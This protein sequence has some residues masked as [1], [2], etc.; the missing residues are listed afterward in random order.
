MGLRLKF[1]LVLLGVFIV[2]LAVSGYTSYELLRRNAMDE[3]ARSAGLMMEAASAIRAYT[4]NHLR[5]KLAATPTDRFLPQSVPAFAATETLNALRKKYPEFAYKEAALNPTNVRDLATDW[6][7]QLVQRF[8]REPAETELRGQ[9]ATPTGTALYM[10]RPI[11]VNFSCLACHNSPETAPPMFVE[12]YGARNGF[13]WR[14]DE[15]IGAQIV[16]VPVDVPLRNARRAFVTFMGSLTA[17][18]GGLFVALNV[19]MT[20]LVVRPVSSMSDSAEQIST[21]DAEAPEFAEGGSDEVA[22]LGRA[23]NRMRRS[24]EQATKMIERK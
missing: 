20:H 5:P 7:A 22:V 11:K 3:V 17:V 9:R 1:N 18:F 16:S 14:V 4:T 8:R 23:F 2:G 13:G 6:E 10:A 24:L 15:I 12:A 21:G 19:M